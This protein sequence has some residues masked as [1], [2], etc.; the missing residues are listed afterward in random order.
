MD[1]EK[2]NLMHQL[3]KAKDELFESC[4]ALTLNR[5]E[6]ALALEKAIQTE[7]VDLN[8]NDSQVK[9]AIEPLDEPTE[10]GLDKVEILITT[11][12]GESLKPVSY[13]HLDVYKRQTAS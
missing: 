3:K 10:I 8:F 12:R 7:L 1:E 9:I 4:H 13:T 5:K 11:N 6:K 2:K